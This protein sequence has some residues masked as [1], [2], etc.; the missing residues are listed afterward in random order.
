MSL[1]TKWETKKNQIKTAYNWS[2]WIL[3]H[4]NPYTELEYIE[5]TGAQRIN[6]GITSDNTLTVEVV[7][8]NPSHTNYENIF[9]IEEQ[10]MRYELRTLR[11]ANQYRF[12]V[13]GGEYSQYISQAQSAF[14]K[15]KMTGTGVCYIDDIQVGNINRTYTNTQNTIKI[16]KGF[17]EYGSFQL[18]SFKIWKNNLLVR[19]FIPVKDS[20]DVVCLYDLVSEMFYYNTGTGVFTPGPEV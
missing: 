19:D 15:I 14:T 17:N 4:S 3:S 2:N 12:S 6:T 10:D 9:G 7:F 13:N 8:K 1:L 20:H 18:K 16:F 11:N 5:S